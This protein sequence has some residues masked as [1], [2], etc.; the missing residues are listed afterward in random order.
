MKYLFL[1]LIGAFCTVGAAQSD[2]SV[3]RSWGGG[4]IVPES[5]YP[6]AIKIF[7][8]DKFRCSAS[9]VGP[10][11]ILTASHCM[12]SEDER[13]AGYFF[14][15]QT[16]YTFSFQNYKDH[17]NKYMD[18][19]YGIVDRDVEGVDPLTISFSSDFSNKMIS[20]GYGCTVKYL[21]ETFVK[22]R[23]SGAES[24]FLVSSN[25]DDPVFACGGDSGGPTLSYNYDLKLRVVGVH[26]FSDVATARKTTG[27][28]RTDS[29][30]FISFTQTF[31]DKNNLKICGYNM[32]CD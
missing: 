24:R 5:K 12:K 32:D 13:N 14:I 25:P 20:L 18:I 6:A 31:A 4:F 2:N 15:A 22:V 23:N 30:E 19:A 17:M 21:T 28:I 16:K 3:E 27:D 29:I 8:N 26:Y 9:L 10:R 1:I 11:V 7:V